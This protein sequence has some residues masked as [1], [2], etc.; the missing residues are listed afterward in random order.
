MTTTNSKMSKCEDGTI[1]CSCPFCPLVV[2]NIQ[3]CD[4][5]GILKKDSIGML[6]PTTLVEN[7]AEAEAN[8]IRD[9]FHTIVLWSLQE[10]KKR[11][12][13]TIDYKTD[14]CELYVKRLHK[15]VK[16]CFHAK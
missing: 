1:K 6:I 14:N 15:R 13:T 3:T 9:S 11:K 12:T 2:L 8:E 5:W 4:V 7:L 16:V 10:M